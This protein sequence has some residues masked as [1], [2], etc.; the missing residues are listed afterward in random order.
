MRF[1]IVPL[2]FTLACT[3]RIGGGP[4]DGEDDIEQAG[5]PS[6]TAAGA[7]ST[8]SADSTEGP[9]STSSNGGETSSGSSSSSS[10]DSASGSDPSGADGG[11]SGSSGDGGTSNTSNDA[12]ASSGG[13][14]ASGGGG[15]SSDPYAAARALCVKTINDYRATVSLGP[16]TDWSS[17][18]TCADGQA[19]SDGASGTA[20]GAFGQCKETAQN[21][22]P[23]WGGAIE[24]VVTGCLAAMWAE[25]PGGGHY[26]NMTS[27]SR[28]TVVCGIH[29]VA[30]GTFWVVQDFK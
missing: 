27:T 6:E 18:N 8:R 17:A 20:H 28:S 24:D 23:G 26:D 15:G 12:G 1:L 9:S 25:G 14:D 4:L 5:T 16:M 3:G 21:E 22:C 29:K 10:P 13:S 30:G 2:L 19:A 7:G 11:A